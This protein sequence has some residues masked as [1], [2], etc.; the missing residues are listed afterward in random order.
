[1]HTKH[2]NVAPAVEQYIE[3]A[4]R[5]AKHPSQRLEPPQQYLIIDCD[6]NHFIELPSPLSNQ[7]QRMVTWCHEP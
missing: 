1:M 4:A 6:W 7:V 5:V 3:H 2:D